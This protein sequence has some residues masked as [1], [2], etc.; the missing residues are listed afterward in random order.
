MSWD[1]RDR[2]EFA[3]V[4]FPCEIATRTAKGLKLS[5]CVENISAGGL[6]VFLKDKLKTSSSVEINISGI[7]KKP[8]NCK[9]KVLWAFSRTDPKNKKDLVFDTGIEFCQ[10]AAKDLEKIKILIDS[11]LSRSCKNDKNI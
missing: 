10:M 6:R 1:T 8:I 11:M 4:K 2:R 5:A 9:G 3:R 7:G